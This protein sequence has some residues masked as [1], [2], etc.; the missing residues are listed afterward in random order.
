ME[1]DHWARLQTELGD[2]WAS[3][4]VAFTDGDPSAPRRRRRCCA[5]AS[6]HAATRFWRSSIS[7]RR[8]QASRQ[9][10]P[11]SRGQHP[12][13]QVRTRLM[14]MGAV[15]A[16]R[17]ARRR[18]HGLASGEP[19]A[20]A[21]R[22]AARCRAAEPPGSRA[23]VGAA[24]DAQEQERRNLARELHDEVGQALTAIKMDIGIALRSD[25]QTARQ[26]RA[27]GGARIAETTLR[28]VRDLSQLLHPSMLDDFGLPDDADRATCA[29]SRKRTGIRAQLAE[30]DGRPAAAGRSRS[31]STAS[32]R[33]RSPTSPS[34][35]APPRARCR[36][37]R[38]RR[39][40]C[41]SSIEDNGR[42]I[43]AATRGSR[44]RRG[45][46][47]IG[48]RERAQALGGTFVIENRAERRHARRGHAAAAVAGGRAA[49]G[50]H[51]R[52]AG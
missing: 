48:M 49:G 43:D 20:A 16:R 2:Y 37:M 51:A 4:D 33:R 41:S 38:R 10:A 44:A 36:S 27:R 47:L 13:S 12:V 22:A 24:G 14:S 8:L 6:C 42:G 40:C 35:A 46:G 29:A 26:G 19:A 5:V 30:T 32:S 7:S 31:A 52:L 17:R 1:R 50:Q 11:P 21:D 3:R 18:R 25:N 45:L 15:D 34:T 39:A 23:A 9:P 28:G